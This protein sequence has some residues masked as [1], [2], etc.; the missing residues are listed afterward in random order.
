M[1]ALLT[2]RAWWLIALLQ[3]VGAGWGYLETHRLTVHTVPV[4]LA[5]LPRP[6]DGYR[7]ALISCLHTRG[8]GLREAALRRRLGHL[9]ADT[10]VIA[11]DVQDFRAPTPRVLEGAMGCLGGLH[12]RN[13]IVVVPGNHDRR[14]VLEKVARS[15]GIEVLA[16]EVRAIRRADATLYL[17]GRAAGGGAADWS[18]LTEN[19]PAGA[20]II[21]VCH[22]PDDA[23][24]AAAAGVHLVLAGHTHGGQICLPGGWPVITETRRI[25]RRFARGL[26]RMPDG[27][28]LYVNRGIGWTF[29][30]ARMFCRPEI[31]LIVLRSTS[32]AGR[33]GAAARGKAVGDAGG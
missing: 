27:T 22:N 18:A 30:P 9:E 14:A 33:A 25:P 19:L 21:G 28:W 31:T 13:G 26:H 8:Y 24:G 23:L 4:P 2:T 20:C 29:V 17:A 32:G 6:F 1:W 10:L 3:G 5:D 7:L 15:A 12:F 11:G 16:D